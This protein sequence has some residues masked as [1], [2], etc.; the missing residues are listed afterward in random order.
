M[1]SK[2]YLSL[3]K[4][5]S[6]Q[7]KA[8]DSENVTITRLIINEMNMYCLNASAPSPI[9]DGEA[10]KVLLKMSKQRK[11]SIGQFKDAHRLDLVQKEEIQLKTIINLLPAQLGASETKEIVA[12]IITDKNITKSSEMGIIMKEINNMPA[13]TIDKS[14]VIKI[15]KEIL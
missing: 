1:S 2:I 5:L 9:S 13:G 3:K 8:K 4:G 6:W 12:K 10:I 15:I 14:L 7:M 11:D